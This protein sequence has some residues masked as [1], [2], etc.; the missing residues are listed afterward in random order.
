MYQINCLQLCLPTLK[1]R[2][3]Q[4]RQI[5]LR[6]MGHKESFSACREAGRK[7]LG[8][9]GISS[10]AKEGKDLLCCTH[11]SP[12]SQHS[13]AIGEIFVQQLYDNQKNG[14]LQRKEQRQEIFHQ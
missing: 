4:K 12:L 1:L 8:V 3:N 14:F 6:G 5:P 13:Y 7:Q 9:F 11:M 10:E 2:E